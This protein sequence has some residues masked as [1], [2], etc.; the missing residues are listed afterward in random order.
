MVT[1]RATKGILDRAPS[2]AATVIRWSTLSEMC[3]TYNHKVLE[4]ACTYDRLQQVG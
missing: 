4:V 2:A 1:A 3:L